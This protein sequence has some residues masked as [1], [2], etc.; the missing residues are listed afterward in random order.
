MT[1]IILDTDVFSD[2]TELR[3]RADEFARLIGEAETTLAFP[4]VAEVHHGAAKARWGA[5]RTERLEA[6]LA[7]YGVLWPTRE[8]LRL[9][10]S[11]RAEAVRR[12]HPL[13]QPE[14]ANDLWIAACAIHYDVPLLTGNGR[15]FAGLPGL[16]LA[17]A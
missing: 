12:G 5:P 1:V 9:W 13:G 8:L 17:A 14:H 16:E 6:D 4:T 3:P 7:D 10:G 2:L 11:L 15:H